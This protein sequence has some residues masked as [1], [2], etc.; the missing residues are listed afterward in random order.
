[1]T[2]T[3]GAAFPLSRRSLRPIPSPTAPHPHCRPHR[4]ATST[5]HRNRGRSEHNL[6][7]TLAC[8][9]TSTAPLLAAS[10]HLC[11]HHEAHHPFIANNSSPH[12]SRNCRGV[13]LAHCLM[14][15]DSR[16]RNSQCGMCASSRFWYWNAYC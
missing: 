7:S 11:L 10:V 9:H 8:I 14:V 6:C 1:M 13:T 2:M 16:E 5:R 12:R 15:W 4:I 3:T